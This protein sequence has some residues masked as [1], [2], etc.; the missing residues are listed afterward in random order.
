MI[1]D[2]DEQLQSE[3]DIGSVPREKVETL[4]GRTIYL[5]I[6]ASEGNAYSQAAFCYGHC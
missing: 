3:S 4:V 6:V 1:K 2:I 5:S